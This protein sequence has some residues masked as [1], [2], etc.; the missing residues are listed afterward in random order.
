M[1]MVCEPVEQGPGQTFGAEHL[2]P[3][4]ERQIGC[5]QGVQVAMPKTATASDNFELSIWRDVKRIFQ[6]RKA[7]A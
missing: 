3:L 2:G 1:N 7:E 4:I 5:H 6:E